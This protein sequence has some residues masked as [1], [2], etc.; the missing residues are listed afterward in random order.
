MPNALGEKIPSFKAITD[1]RIN[2]YQAAAGQTLE[3]GDLV[4]RNA[5]GYVERCVTE[6]TGKVLGVC[7]SRH[8]STALGDRVSVNDNP[9]AQFLA[10]GDGANLSQANIATGTY[11]DIVLDDGNKF[12]VDTATAGTTPTIKVIAL[13]EFHNTAMGQTEYAFATG[14]GV[15]VEINNH[16]RRA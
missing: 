13:E 15:I 1:D 14:D 9:G 10:Y 2:A 4:K 11:Y 12:R 7:V 16:E 6:E 5:A 3:P 8:A